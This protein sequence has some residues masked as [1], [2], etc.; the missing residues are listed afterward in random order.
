MYC[1]P[2]YLSLSVTYTVVDHLFT[3][4]KSKCRIMKPFTI[5]V[6]AKYITMRSA[7]A[8]DIYIKFSMTIKQE[9]LQFSH[10]FTMFRTTAWML[11]TVCL[12]LQVNCC[13]KPTPAPAPCFHTGES[14]AGSA[15]AAVTVGT[16]TVE[17]YSGP[18]AA[19]PVTIGTPESCQAKCQVCI[20]TICTRGKAGKGRHVNFL[21]NLWGKINLSYLI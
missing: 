10:V 8:L 5:C 4:I 11:V 6:V 15:G 20:D 18:A 19:N 7:G 17:F 14:P 2:Y 9:C 12:I 21:C 3:L 16:P 1:K 13:P